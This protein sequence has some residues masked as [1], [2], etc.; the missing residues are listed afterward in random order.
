MSIKDGALAYAS[1]RLGPEPSLWSMLEEISARLGAPGLDLDE[2]GAAPEPS[3]SDWPDAALDAALPPRGDLERIPSA[4]RISASLDPVEGRWW[5]AKERR[6]AALDVL[7][8][9]AV[10][11][12]L[13]AL[14]VSGQ[15]GRAWAA[16]GVRAGIE[17]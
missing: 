16:C 8:R 13:A 4:P 12:Q 3:H 6:S 7:A 1:G 15:D 2:D 11:R 14:G 9:A 5:G 10:C 17:T